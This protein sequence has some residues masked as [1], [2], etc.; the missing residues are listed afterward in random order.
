MAC[1]RTQRQ[2]FG[3]AIDLPDDL[4]S[5]AFG[6][7]RFVLSERNGLPP[8]ADVTEVRLFDGQ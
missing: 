2:D 3:W 4:A 1:H 6:A 8:P 7:E 5:M